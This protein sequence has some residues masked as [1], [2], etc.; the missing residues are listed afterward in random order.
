MLTT[1]VQWKQLVEHVRVA[2]LSRRRVLQQKAHTLWNLGNVSLM[3]SEVAAAMTRGATD[4]CTRK[5]L[6]LAATCNGPVNVVNNAHGCPKPCSWSNPWLTWSHV[7]CEDM[8]KPSW[9]KQRQCHLENANWTF[10]TCMYACQRPS[11]Q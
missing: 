9:V 4:V 5:S 1:D 7:M 2:H 8:S 3:R 11:D 10:K 6:N